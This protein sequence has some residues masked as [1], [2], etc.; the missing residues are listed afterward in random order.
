MI[1]TIFLPN[2]IFCTCHLCNGDLVPYY[3]NI[4]K[5]LECLTYAAAN[6]HSQSMLYHSDYFNIFAWQNYVEREQREEH[7]GNIIGNSVLWA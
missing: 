5:K 7:T 6:L 2:R 1:E 3:E 4:L